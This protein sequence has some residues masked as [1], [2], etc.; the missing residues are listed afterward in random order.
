M[1]DKLIPKKMTTLY[2]LTILLIFSCSISVA[3]E[4]R[5][6]NPDDLFKVARETAFAGKRE[7]A[8]EMLREVLSKAPDYTEVRVFLARTLAWDS[9]YEEAEKELITVLSS[10]PNDFEALNVLLDVQIWSE[11][12]NDAL[13]TVDDGL[14]IHP[15]SEDYL[16]KKALI[17]KNLN[18]PDDAGPVLAR[19]LELNPSHEKGNALMVEL[20][21]RSMKHYVGLTMGLDVFSKAYT[22]AYSSSVNFGTTHRWG[23]SIVRVNYANRFSSQGVQPEI[24]LYPRIANGVYAYVNYG[25]SQ[26]DLFPQHRVGGEIYTKLPKSFEASLGA[27]YLYFNGSTSVLLYTGSIGYYVKNYWIS[28]RPYLSSDSHGTSFSSTATVRYYFANSENY[29]GFNLGYGFSPDE[30]RI[31][32]YNGLS[33]DRINLLKSEKVGLTWQKT[34]P[35]NFTLSVYFNL[36]YQELSLDLGKYTWITSSSVWVRKRF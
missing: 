18:R 22:N 25:Y 27:R 15:N 33:P 34:L 23:S 28:F 6:L 4:W 11:R 16:Y 14:N 24:D 10:Q 13:S 9:K 2:G 20:K 19:L 26:I 17:L 5:Q 8:R 12:Y 36:A 32:S 29:L 3:Q 1:K 35:K 31:Q 7:E 30:R 21:Q